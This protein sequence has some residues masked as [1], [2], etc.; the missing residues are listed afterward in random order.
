M[1]KRH[2]TGSRR[3]RGERGQVLILAVVAL[4][5][6]I[7]AVLL[8]FDVQTVIRGKVKAQNGVDAAALTG[9]EWQKHSLNLIGELN[10]VRA[11]GTLISDPFFAR[12][13]L[14]APSETGNAAEFFADLPQ[15]ITQEEFTL[16]PEKAEFYNEDG[17]LNVEKLIREVLRVE[18]QKRYL[19][20]LDDLVSQ[21]Q[22]RIAFTGPLIGFGAAQQAAKNNGI[23]FDSE[24][25]DFYIKYLNLVG[26]NGI[27]ERITPVFVHDYAWRAPYVSMLES[28]LD[29]SAFHNDFT[30]NTENRAYGIAAGTKFKFV[31][32]PSLVTDPPTDFSIYLGDKNFYD[33]IHA[34]DWCGLDR[35]LRLDFNGNWWGDF[36]CELDENFSN[37]SEILPL[38]ISFSDMPGTYESANGEAKALDRF[39]EARKERLFSE[40]FNRENPYEYTVIDDVVKREEHEEKRHTYYTLTNISITINTA[41]FEQS[42][43]D[44]DADRR[45]D[46]LPRLSWAVFDEEWASFG[47]DREEWE[48]YLRGRFK[49]GMDYRSGALAYFEAKQDTV[50]ISGSM[51]RPRRGS[52]APDVGQVF[53]NTAA[54]SDA[55]GVSRALGRLNS[56]SVERIE[57]NAEA[58]PI[59]RIRTKDGQYLRPFEAGRMVLPVFTE[60]ALIPIAMEPV[61]GFSML[62]LDWL[63]YLTEFVPLLSGS[64]SL[65][66][67]W[68]RAVELYPTHLGY[69]AYYVAALAMLG[70]PVFRQAGLDWLDATAVWTK[71]ERGNRIPMYTNREY[72]CTGRRGESGGS[73]GWSGTVFSNGGP[74]KLH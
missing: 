65:E 1:T 54:D 73:G 62:D 18:K 68:E 41:I 52:R 9:A 53:S 20:A 45:Y 21:L 27:Y 33:M 46:L 8:L 26:N 6:V 12:G 19:D 30:G 44:E 4:I 51:G 47:S 57:T 61:D 70:N 24:A 32:M 69:Y 13:I 31:G 35:L 3:R 10:L 56:N 58:K 11:T 28:I 16:F 37:Q 71:D 48:E 74:S 64:P 38:H 17:T 34:R 7:I 59:G 36:E 66:D 50:T 60:T 49:P 2:A 15:P 22:T 39:A 29:Y 5:L 25:S 43:N 14:D 67:A 63:Y 55:R 42:Y 72:N 40:T 23:T